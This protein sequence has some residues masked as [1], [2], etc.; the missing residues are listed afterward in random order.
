MDQ[1]QINDI[2]R[3][4]MAQMGISGTPEDASAPAVQPSASVESVAL[5]LGSPEA[6]QWIGVENPHRAE[7][8]QE[9]R[10]STASRVCSGRA[11]VRPRTQSLLRFLADHSRSKDTVLKEVPAEW[12]ASK[13]LLA[14]Q[15]EITDKNQYLTRPDMGRILSPA[16]VEQLKSQCVQAPDVQ[17]VVSDGLST[18]AVTANYDE[19]LPPL[20]KGLEQ[21]GLKVGTPM[22]VRYGRVKIEDQIGETLGA[23]V[24]VL[25]VGERPGLGQSESLSCYAVYAPTVAKT[26]EADRTCISNIHR[27]GTPPVEAAAVIVDLAKRMLEQKAS[28]INMNR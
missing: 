14:L 10:N 26:V 4:V 25:L 15:S 9:L 11:G 22:F 8:L 16:S 17:V 21:A 24:V 6:K 5:D 3:S 1:K 18:D 12:V 2:V 28:G 13:G 23:K 19:I 20:M 7:V 27:A